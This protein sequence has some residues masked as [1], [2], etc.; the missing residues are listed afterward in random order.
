MNVH[1]FDS[2]SPLALVLEGEPDRLAYQEAVHLAEL[3][4]AS[5][6]P[7]TQTS[8]IPAYAGTNATVCFKVTGMGVR[9]VSDYPTDDD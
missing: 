6:D 9:A 4:S 7:V 1:K 5:Y 2:S 8:N 3:I